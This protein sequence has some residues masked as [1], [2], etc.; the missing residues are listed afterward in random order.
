MLNYYR[1]DRGLAVKVSPFLG[2]EKA[3][4]IIEKL[5]KNEGVFRDLKRSAEAMSP[6]EK[7]RTKKFS[8][9]KRQRKLKKELEKEK[10]NKKGKRSNAN[11]K[12]CRL[13]P[14]HWN[15][16]KDIADIKEH[17]A[18]APL[19]SDNTVN[20]VIPAGKIKTVIV[21]AET[22][23]GFYVIVK[24]KGRRRYGFPGGGVNCREAPFETGNR[25]FLEE[26]GFFPDITKKDIFYY[27]PL[28]DDCDYNGGIVYL[29]AA[30]KRL[31]AYT[32]NKVDEI[33]EKGYEIEDLRYL[34]GKEIIQAIKD[35]FILP[36]HIAIWEELEKR[37]K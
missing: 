1:V 37:Q 16:S 22:V 11:F 33:S 10:K 23:D 14:E 13:N 29:A 34:T 32:V 31:A 3:I 27:L 4:K 19:S 15:F 35:G 5:A 8:A 30:Y 9:L 24:V 12:N 2:F 18:P 6:S 7:R 25:E 20:T 17:S 26:V 21:I 28:K 36:N